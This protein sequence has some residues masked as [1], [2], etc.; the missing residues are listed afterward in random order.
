MLRIAPVVVDDY[1]AAVA[2]WER[3]GGLSDIEPIDVWT[4]ILTRN[5]GLAQA[6][7]EGDRLVG[8]VM[9]GH[10]GRRSTLYHLAVEPE[11]R[12]QKIADRLIAAAR[13]AL[14]SEGI[15]RTMAFVFRSNEP[16]VAYW[17]RQGWTRRDELF[18]YDTR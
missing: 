3:C 9:A 16:G 13:T 1:A 8:I 4:R 14:A 10:D 11:L 5:V 6:A 7:W 2:L 17:E 12:R 15:T 18:V